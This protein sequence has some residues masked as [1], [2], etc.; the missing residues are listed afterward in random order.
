MW[1]GAIVA[2]FGTPY[3]RLQ[4]LAAPLSPI[5]KLWAFL[6]VPVIRVCGDVA[7]MIGYP[8]GVWWRVTRP[9]GFSK[10]S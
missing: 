4:N 2:L 5:E 8:V 6:W 3:R 7:K 1:L 10:Q 9:D